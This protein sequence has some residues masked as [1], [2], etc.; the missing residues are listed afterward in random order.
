M[1]LGALACYFD[2]R[3]QGSGE[4]RSTTEQGRIT[5]WKQVVRATGAA[6]SVWGSGCGLWGEVAAGPCSCQWLHCEGGTGGEHA[7]ACTGAAVQ[8]RDVVVVSGVCGNVS[9]AVLL[10]PTHVCCC[11]LGAGSHSSGEIRV[12]ESRCCYVPGI[13]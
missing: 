10:R 5:V 11:L 2:G 4:G 13:P 7:V 9:V 6:V 8:N 1:V 3:V 12:S